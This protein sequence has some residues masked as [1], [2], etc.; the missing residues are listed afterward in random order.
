MCAN[1]VV[2]F[3]NQNIGRVLK[4]IVA[5]GALTLGGLIYVIFRSG[6]LLMF[7]WFDTL[8]LTDFIARLRMDY[9]STN[10]WDWMNYNMP[11][12]LWLFSYMFIIDA[13]WNDYKNRTFKCFVYALPIAAIFSELLQL[14]KILPGTFDVM[15]VISY[16]IS[17]ILFITITK[18]SK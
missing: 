12:G 14:L 5:V 4:V 15:D 8:G 9:G 18:I 3:Y 17:I 2:C 13:L 6:H 7:H 16:S 10:L 11:A 1:M